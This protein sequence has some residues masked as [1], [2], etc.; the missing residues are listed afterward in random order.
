MNSLYANFLNEIERLSR[1][2]KT[3]G[4]ALLT[5]LLPVLAAWALTAMPDG[6]AVQSALAGNLPMLLLQPF[7]LALLP[8]FLFMTAADLFAGEVA[9][10][11]LKLTLLRP[12]TRAKVYA[13]KALAL[14]F[15]AAVLLAAL[16]IAAAASGVLIA[17][18]E[19]GQGLA[20]S[21]K[22]YAVTLL[23]MIAA[24][25][26]AT[27]VSLSVGSVGGA[28]ALMLLIYAAAKLLPFILPQAA[29]W[30]AFSYT[31]WQVLWAGDGAPAGSLLRASGVLIAYCIM[32]YTAG[33]VLL[34][35]KK[36]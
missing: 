5:V 11:T 22:A 1:R 15:Y 27:L 21:L 24:G 25:W 35:R 16:W 23:P 8:L 34:E 10:G 18:G 33:V 26:L 19:A 31:D 7:A 3:Q 12:I 6:S 30:S 29:V 32:A 20:G 28:L 9:A 2:R 17:G 14:A 4:F 13:S 36:C